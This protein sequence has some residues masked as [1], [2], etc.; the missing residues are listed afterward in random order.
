M[1]VGAATSNGLV[2]DHNE[3]AYWVSD[4]V[5]AVCDGMGGHQAGEVAAAIAVDVFKSCDFSA[6]PPMDA[7]MDA[8]MSAHRAIQAQ[9]KAPHL[10]GMGTTATL[11][12]I[13]KDG[14]AYHL[15]LGH[16]GDSRAYMLHN[17]KLT[18]ITSDH[19]IVGELVRNGNL[20]KD[21]AF[22]HPH[23]HVV[24]QALGIGEIEI[25]TFSAPLVPTDWILLC[26]DGLTDVVA[27]EQIEAVLLQHDP[28]GAACEL[29]EIANANGGPDNVTVILVE[30]P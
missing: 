11:A 16:V 1:R 10:R 25:E 13:V 12:Y 4:N 2:R 14:T 27:D 20:S 5:F 8:I 28:E 26:T 21:E 22:H 3:D 18:Q 30:I 9:A 19:S 6:K 23:R 15:Y 29:I 17:G 7:V 24:T